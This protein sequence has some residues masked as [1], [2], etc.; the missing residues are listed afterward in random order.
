[1]RLVPSRSQ[2]MASGYA[3]MKKLFGAGEPT[4]VFC[5][6]DSTAIGAM[7]ALEEAGRRIPEDVSVVGFDDGE[8]AEYAN[9]PLTTVRQP[10]EQMGRE[11]ARELVR[12]MRGAPTGSHV[13]DVHLVVRGSTCPRR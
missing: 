9:P 1:M 3:A 13:L 4:A 7:R 10:R 8:L 11:G 5:I 6:N 12:A 2:F